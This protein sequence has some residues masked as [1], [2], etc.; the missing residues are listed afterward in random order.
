[1]RFILRIGIGTSVQLISVGLSCVIEWSQILQGH[2]NFSA[3]L[4]ANS[5]ICWICL[6]YCKFALTTRSSVFPFL[7]NFRTKTGPGKLSQLGRDFPRDDL[8]E[9]FKNLS[10]GVAFV[11]VQINDLNACI[12]WGSTDSQAFIWRLRDFKMHEIAFHITPLQRST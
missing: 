9:K 10:R 6:N 3:I 11:N 12:T 4:I 1:M 2:I 7:T 5:C 8:L